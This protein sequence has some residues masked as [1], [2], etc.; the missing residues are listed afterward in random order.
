VDLASAAR[1][2]LEQPW[3]LAAD[4]PLDVPAPATAAAGAGAET[5]RR[6]LVRVALDEESTSALLRET[7]GQGSARV[8]ELLVAALARALAAWTGSER[9]ALDLEGHGR[10]ELFPDLDLSRTVGWFTALYPVLLEVE[11]D[12]DP[13]T[14]LASIR[15]QLRRI[16]ERG[17]VWGLARYL[18]G[19]PRLQSM[20]AALP[21]PRVAF[22]YLGQFGLGRGDG[23][24][25][26]ASD[27]PAGPMRSPR[28]R[29]LHGLEINAA[30]T[31]GRLQFE[32]DYDPGRHKEATIRRVADGLVA[33][34]H[35]L[36]EAGRARG[37]GRLTASDVA[38]FGWTAADLDDI[39][40]DLGRPRRGAGPT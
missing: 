14:A 19:D 22:N 12:A 2:W 34:L 11:R 13:L 4:P 3:D 20:L 15:E 39:Y 24:A 26:I 30:V 5:G 27:R 8:D 21:A 40:S 35:A 37:A 36:I 33:E 10:Q 18:S 38:D 32:L 7:P 31:A 25:F 1:A 23:A 16:P 17:L 6:A 28:Q 29:R 9:V